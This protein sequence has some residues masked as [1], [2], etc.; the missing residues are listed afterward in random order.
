M[1][2]EGNSSCSL[3]DF[4]LRRYD[5][6]IMSEHLPDFIDPS[7]L[8]E[9]R[10]RLRGSIELRKL[11][12][13]ADLLF[14]QRGIARLDLRFGINERRWEVHGEVNAELVLQCQFCLEPLRLPVECPVNLA[15]A[16]TVD[17]ALLL[18]DDMEALMVDPGG[19]VALVD[20]VQD[21]LLLAIPTIPR[22]TN[23]GFPRQPEIKIP[24]PHPFAKLAELMKQT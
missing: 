2:I 18:P 19:E 16:T 5:S 17:E 6:Q 8:A 3:T 24:R 9:K 12:R 10:A 23:C 13:L 21:E 1:K 4:Q 14:D 11:D 7:S 15:V 22:H 20:I